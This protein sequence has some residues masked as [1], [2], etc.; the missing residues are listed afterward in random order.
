MN[1][2]YYLLKRK[3]GAKK[4]LRVPYI[5]QNSLPSADNSVPSVNKSLF[6][7]SS[8]TVVLERTNEGE[9]FGITVT[10]SCP[11]RIAS[12]APNSSASMAGLQKGDCLVRINNQNVSRSISNSVTKMLNNNDKHLV[13]DIYR[14]RP[15]SSSIGSS[16]GRSI[17]CEGAVNDDYKEEF[18]EDDENIYE[19]DI[20]ERNIDPDDKEN[21]PSPSIQGAIYRSPSIGLML[22]PP[23]GC[24]SPDVSI[25][26]QDDRVSAIKDLVKTEREFS[27]KMSIGVTRYSKPLRG[28]LRQMFS[29]KKHTDDWKPWSHLFLN[30]EKLGQLSNIQLTQLDPDGSI[31]DMN[32]GGLYKAR[33]RSMCEEY[34]YFS[35]NLYTA[36]QL[37]EELQDYNE[38]REF[39]KVRSIIMNN[40]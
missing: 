31:D 11:A 20:F 17:D 14:K 19:N 10:G 39:M 37:L 22:P 26:S 1:D 27:N 15:K 29:S 33:L 28:G 8:S 7:M 32:V 3:T 35:K 25:L 34:S 38:F 24:S 21:L 5:S 18:Y 16:T 9:S 6:G 23:A 13:L 40:K 4:H 12:V 30:I 2:W 36:I